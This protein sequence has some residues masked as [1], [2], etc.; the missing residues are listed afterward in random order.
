MAP[1]PDDRCGARSR[2]TTHDPEP[3]VPETELLGLT[4]AGRALM[5][6]LREDERFRDV[7]ADPFGETGAPPAAAA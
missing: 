3:H 7:L 6:L 2:R 4:P 1:R 5:D